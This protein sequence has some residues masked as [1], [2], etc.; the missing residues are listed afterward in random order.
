MESRIHN[1]EICQI[2]FETKKIDVTEITE[3]LVFNCYWKKLE[4]KLTKMNTQKYVRTRH[5]VLLHVEL[6]SCI[7]HR[8]GFSVVY[9]SPLMFFFA[10][11]KTTK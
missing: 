1:S 2:I 3:K 6:K 9:Q 7:L 4:K 10:E 5:D 8:P 11:L